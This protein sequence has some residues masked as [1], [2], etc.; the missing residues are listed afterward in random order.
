M[1]LILKYTYSFSHSHQVLSSHYCT[2]CTHRIYKDRYHYLS[3]WGLWE[4][5]QDDILHSDY[6]W[7]VMMP[8]WIPFHPHE[9][10]C[11]S[12][13]TY[14]SC[15][16]L[17]IC[18]GAH[19]PAS[20]LGKENMRRIS[21]S[22]RECNAGVACMLLSKILSVSVQGLCATSPFL[23]PMPPTLFWLRWP[24]LHLVIS[25][26]TQDTENSRAVITH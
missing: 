19:H 10:I 24:L 21:P 1:S 23:S 14:G 17:S 16:P 12:E 15:K 25:P 22:A 11:L 4:L 6:L 9:V 8:K 13:E 7:I 2:Y 20:V 3:I 5:Q 26:L 18:Q